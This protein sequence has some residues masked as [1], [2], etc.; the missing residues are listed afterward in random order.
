MKQ[1]SPSFPKRKLTSFICRPDARGPYCFASSEG[2]IQ[3]LWSEKRMAG[4][5]EHAKPGRINT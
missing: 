4:W 1:Q 5:L 3:K 2:K